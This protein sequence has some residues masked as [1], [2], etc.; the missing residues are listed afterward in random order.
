M[1]KQ[2]GI[3]KIQGTVAGLTAVESDAYG[4][5]LRRA[6]GTVKNVEVNE[7]LQGNA[8]HAKPINAF[9][10]PLLRQF[11]RLDDGFAP[12]NLWSRMNGRMLRAKDIKAEKLLHA[13]NGIEINER[14]PFEKL[15][16]TA[17]KFEFA[18]RKEQLIVGVELLSH[19]DF[20]SKLEASQFLFEVHVLFYEG[21]E[22]WSSQVLHTGWKSLKAKLEKHE[23]KFVIPK[24]AKYF[25]AVAGV[26]GGTNGKAVENFLA[27]G[28]VVCG[29]GKCLEKPRGACRKSL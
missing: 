10:S 12:G 13:L 4:D 23:L 18:K 19:P 11:K 9:G 22:G 24:G 3:I 17:P 25:L 27:R 7:V 14:Y 15:F 29:W 20:P 5:H 2:K 1:A 21:K 16:A 28:Y 8:D 26:K 6:R